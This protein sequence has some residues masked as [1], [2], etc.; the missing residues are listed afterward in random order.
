MVIL[1]NPYFNLSGY[2]GSDSNGALLGNAYDYGTDNV[3]V[4]VSGFSGPS[5]GGLVS[6]CQGT[7]S[8]PIQWAASLNGSIDT[9]G[10]ATLSGWINSTLGGSLMTLSCTNAK[11]SM[12]GQVEVPDPYIAGFSI[13]I[14]PPTTLP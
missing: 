8:L 6:T 13:Q 9:N 7:G 1:G 3:E 4:Q 12:D 2:L 14:L 5:I 11:G 10:Q